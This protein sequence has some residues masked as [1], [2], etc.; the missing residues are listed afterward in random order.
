LARDDPAEASLDKL[1]ALLSQAAEN[2]SAV[3]PLFAELLGIPVAGRY[4]PL[5]LTPQQIKARTFEALLAQLAGLA[6]RQPVLMML[7]D[8][9]WLDPTS[10]DLF[11]LVVQRLEGIPVLLVVT[12]R[13]EA[14]PLWM[15]RSQ[16]TLLNIERMAPTQTRMLAE[17]AAGAR[18]L[19]KELLEQIVAKTDGVPLFVEELTKTV[20]EGG[21]LGATGQSLA[22]PSTLHD[23]LIARLDGVGRFK[24]VAQVA[25]VIGR[26]FSHE[27]LAAV[28]PLDEEELR[29]RIHRLAAAELLFVRGTPPEAVYS[30]KHALVRDAAYA[31]LL[32]GRCRDRHMALARVLETRW[33]ATKDAQPELLAHPYTQA[34]AHALAV[35]HCL[36][37]GHKA[38]RR[39]GAA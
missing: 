5:G 6:S 37:A 36:A 24:E 10:R 29:Q 38:L 22:I 12:S 27:L 1:E 23:S 11:D 13:P 25:A 20:L 21:S 9:H 30:F 34:G 14:E 33:P 35:P 28:S 26:E 2:V 16:V 15:G 17:R 39:W 19:P 18:V 8:A 3:A 4:G 32:K 7:E 31:S